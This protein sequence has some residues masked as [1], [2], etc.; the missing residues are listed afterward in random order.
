M[1]LRCRGTATLLYGN[2][3]TSSNSIYLNS[4]RDGTAGGSWA[5]GF[6]AFLLVRRLWFSVYSWGVLAYW[7]GG[8]L[9]CSPT[10]VEQL[11]FIA[12]FSQSTTCIAPGRFRRISWALASTIPFAVG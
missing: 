2:D 4:G 7:L 12:G 8:L 6:A 3:A 10:S 5:V 11:E 9:K 1:L